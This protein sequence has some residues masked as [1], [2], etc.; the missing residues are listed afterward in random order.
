MDRSGLWMV[1]SDQKGT[2]RALR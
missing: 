2:C 1:G